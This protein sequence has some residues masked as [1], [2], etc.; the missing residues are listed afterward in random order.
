MFTD[1]YQYYR[2]LRFIDTYRFFFKIDIIL[3]QDYKK[4]LIH[5]WVIDIDVHRYSSIFIDLR[6]LSIITDIF[7]KSILHIRTIKAYCIT[8]NIDISSVDIEAINIDI[9]LFIR[10][11][12][13][14]HLTVAIDVLLYRKV[15]IYLK[16]SLRNVCRTHRC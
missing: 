3:Y 14:L 12:W 5:Q 11:Y 10:K 9:Y 1:T 16:P 8:I 13:Y 4:V 2:C 7:S 6:D 15:Q